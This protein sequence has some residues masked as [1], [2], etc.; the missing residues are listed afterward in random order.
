MRIEIVNYLVNER[1]LFYWTL[2]DGPGM[3]DKAAGHATSLEEALKK[4]LYWRTQIGNDY[5][6]SAGIEIESQTVGD[7]PSGGSEHSDNR[8][9]EHGDPANEPTH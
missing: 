4:I 2:F 3:T 9:G 7:R 6:E 1:E 8:S 5:A